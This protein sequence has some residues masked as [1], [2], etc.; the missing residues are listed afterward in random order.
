M[1]FDKQKMIYILRILFCVS[2]FSL[3]ATWLFRLPEKK[4][5]VV[6][7][8]HKLET[9]IEEPKP[10]EIKVQAP[11][12][13]KDDLPSF[14]NLT[15]EPKKPEKEK[16]DINIISIKLPQVATSTR[17]VLQT[18]KNESSTDTEV[19]LRK[20]ILVDT[21]L[22]RPIKDLILENTWLPTYTNPGEQ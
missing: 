6:I 1:K 18:P 2:L 14:A 12:V 21:K 4:E 7:K 8:E 10:K 11:I 22:K 3:W 17:K 19:P 15:I 5:K 9:K 20:K 16:K 13:K